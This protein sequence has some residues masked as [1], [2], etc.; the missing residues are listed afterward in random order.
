M[1]YEVQKAFDELRN[2]IWMLVIPLAMGI[3]ALFGYYQW[4]IQDNE[5]TERLEDLEPLSSGEIYEVESSECTQPKPEGTGH[6]CA[7]SIEWWSPTEFTN[8]IGGQCYIPAH[9]SELINLLDEM[10]R[11]YPVIWIPG[12][13]PLVLLGIVI[14]KITKARR[15]LNAVIESQHSSD[16]V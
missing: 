13:V 3:I 10:E 14:N 4:M 7:Q 6:I 12:L 15:A 2:A 8:C 9:L 11:S 1:N 5:W 16:L